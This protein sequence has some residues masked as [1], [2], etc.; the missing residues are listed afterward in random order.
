MAV[1]PQIAAAQG[2]TLDRPVEQGALV[3]GRTEPGTKVVVDGRALQV[4]RGGRFVF[5][6]DRD[7]KKPLKIALIHPGQQSETTYL[8][9]K[10]RAWRKQFIT[11]IPP[12]LVTP[13]PTLMKRLEREYFLVLGVRKADSGMTHWTQ[14]LRWPA[15]GRISGVFGSQRFYNGKPRSY[16][17]GVDV[18]VPQG[19]KVRAPIGGIVSLTHEGLYFAGM[20]VMVD[21]GH[22][23][24]S[25]FI[26][27]SR[28]LVKKGDRVRQ[29][30]VIGL[31]GRTGRATGAH[32]HWSMSWFQ[33]RIDPHRVVGPMP[34]PKVKAKPRPVKAKRPTGG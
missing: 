29:G 18:A 5:G 22:G 8:P 27:L 2:F 24:Q 1:I 10:P 3:F 16:H 32:L 9:I 17:S 15:R 20:T 28:T 11:G 33:T 30:Q 6:V 12:A 23:V 21:H 7:A 19:W 13:P 31:V 34:R 4:T 26:H 14:K 25:S